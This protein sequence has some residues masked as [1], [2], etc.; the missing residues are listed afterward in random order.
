MM[1]ARLAWILRSGDS[2]LSADRLH[3]AWAYLLVPRY[4]RGLILRAAPL[5]V[6]C[7]ADLSAAVR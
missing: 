4:R 6:L 7:A 2:K 3:Q 5:R 1:T